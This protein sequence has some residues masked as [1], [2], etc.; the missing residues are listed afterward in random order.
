MLPEDREANS[1]RTMMIGEDG[2]TYPWAMW[3]DSDRRLWLYPDYPVHS[4]P[5]GTLRMRVEL[6]EDGWHVWPP[7]GKAYAPQ[8]EPGYVSPR[9]TEYLPVAGMW[10]Q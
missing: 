1:I 9:Y 6:R 2:Y 5:A 7:E 10:G 8:S 4:T 3:A